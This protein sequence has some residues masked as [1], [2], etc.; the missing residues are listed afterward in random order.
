MR[1]VAPPA[2]LLARFVGI[3]LLIALAVIGAG[4][5]I[6]S[7]QGGTGTLSLPNLA[8]QIGLPG[9][10]DSTSDLLSAVEADG[11][12]ALLSL[13]AGLAAMLIGILLA[14]GAL[15]RPSERNFEA[16]DST[17]GRLCARRRP[18]AS[19]AGDLARRVDGVTD[20]SASAR[21][22]R[23]GGRISITAVHRREDREGVRERV[24]SAVA[25]LRSTFGLRTDVETEHG[26]K[27]NRVE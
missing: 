21:P 9:L 3:V 23:R 11:P 12:I 7:I 13:L 4:V 5:A 27:G 2:R 22:S 20:A 16:D 6:Y 26:G 25:S 24:E 14:I 19:A 1:A 18:L 15:T 17:E 8:Q 10:R